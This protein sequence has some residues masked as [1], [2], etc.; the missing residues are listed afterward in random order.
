MLSRLRNP[1]DAEAWRTFESRYRGLIWR[2]CRRR[3]LQTADA[4]D[5]SQVVLLALARAFPGFRFQPERGRFRNYLGRVTDNAVRHHLACPERGPLLLESSMLDSLAQASTEEPEAD[6]LDEWTQHHLGMALRTLRGSTSPAS[7]AVF[8]RL[9]AGD[10]VA[11]VARST[12][13]TI[14]AVYKV[15]QRVA[16]RLKQEIEQQLRDE[17]PSAG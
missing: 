14:E 5:V 8:E 2:Y 13:S 4:E 17:D 6:W 10:T 3:G 15:K 9:L 11:E 1:A 12:G 16:E 7:L